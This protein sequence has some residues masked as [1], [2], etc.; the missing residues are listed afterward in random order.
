[1][2]VH[3]RKLKKARQV[4]K[5]YW[6]KVKLLDYDANGVYRQRKPSSRYSLFTYAAKNK[7]LENEKDPERQ[8]YAQRYQQI[9]KAHQA[10]P[11][12]PL[13][14]VDLWLLAREAFGRSLY[15]NETDSFAVMLSL[16]Q[17]KRKTV[18][19]KAHG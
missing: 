5:P 1:M 9:T 16:K 4:D 10:N 8:R 19:V 15:E 7:L 12:Q 13:A 11:P 6:E 2:H 3:R 17:C 14:L 18:L